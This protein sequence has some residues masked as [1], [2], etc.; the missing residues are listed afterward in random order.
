[1]A[2]IAGAILFVSLKSSDHDTSF[3]TVSVQ[4]GTFEVSV[5]V[6]GE[7][8]AK[9]KAYINAPEELMNRRMGYIRTKI[10]DM[11][12]EGTVVDSG[13]YVARLDESE[14]VNQ[15]SELETQLSKQQAELLKTKLDTTLSMREL[16]NQL[17][18][19]KFGLEEKE[20]VVK[21]S[22]YEPPAT[23]RQ[24]EIA[25]D[26]A[27]RE[28]EEAKISFKIKKKQK[29]AAIADVYLQLNKLEKRKQDMQNLISKFTIFADKPGMVIY[30]R[31]RGGNIRGIGS[32]IAQW[33]MG[34]ATLP[35]M[36][37]MVSK[38]YVNEIDINKVKKGQPVIVKLDAV[39]GKEIE[40]FVS[41]VANVGTQL[42][43][44]DA[45]VF[46]VI[47]EI[48]KADSIMRP[49]MTTS[50]TIVC[51]QQEEV[52]FLP[53]EAVQ[54]NDTVSYVFIDGSRQIVE[55]GSSNDNFVVIKN[56][57]KENQQVILN[58][59]EEVENYPFSSL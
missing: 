3:L 30:I 14:I 9:N 29:E 1:M 17:K 19:M 52:L 13:D 43:G 27:K 57:L 53:L 31:D 15:L 10:Q 54:T 33:N 20:L 32:E 36:S 38:T 50:N 8:E 49:A 5:T 6:T 42:P 25:L 46:E 41:S 28:Y 39:S 59:P 18:D 35:D 24:A 44:S 2:I 55:L 40:G 58:Q 12:P 37:K 22:I 45:K 34:V 51:E 4:K 56:G 26:K 47:V 23:L 21:Q 16:R 48:S 11:V 7:L